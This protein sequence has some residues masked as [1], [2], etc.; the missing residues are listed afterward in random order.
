M[1]E[2]RYIR[3]VGALRNLDGEVRMQLQQVTRKYPFRANNYYLSL[4]DWTD[5]SDP[6]RHIVVPQQG[7]LEQ[8]G[9]LDASE[10]K[11][12]YVAPGCQHKYPHTVLLLCTEMCGAFCRFCFRKRL[13]M[14]KTGETAIDLTPGLEYIRRTPQVTNVLLT[15]GDPLFLSTARLSEIIS[16]VREIP[17]VKIIRL[18]S[19]MPAFNPYRIIRDPELLELLARYSSPSGRIYVMTHFNVPRELTAPAMKALDLLM[20]AGVTLANQSP[21]LRGI[22]DNP[23]VLAELMRRLSFAGVPPYYFFQCRPTEGNRPFQLPLVQAY[24]L[25]EK[26]KSKVSGLA[27]RARLVMSHASGKIEIVGVTREHI[28]VKYHRARDPQDEGRLVAL[29][30]DDSAAWLDDLLPAKR[31]GVRFRQ[32]SSDDPNRFSPECG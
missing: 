21:I 15:G 22:N 20:K 10:E 29:T 12:N 6:I 25:L 31:P 23:E 9:V 4:I 30:R 11:T 7:E 24:R 27:K 5:P 3:N 32:F 16:R 8:F 26:A 19:K 28:H 1:P 14:E 17:H 2:I 13:F 18:G